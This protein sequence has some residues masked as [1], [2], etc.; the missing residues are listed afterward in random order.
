MKMI[1]VAALILAI[2]LPIVPARE[3]SPAEQTPGRPIY[4][5][6]QYKSPSCWVLGLG[7]TY[8]LGSLNDTCSLEF[9]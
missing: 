9:F 2:I 7:F 6:V 8:Y 5:P 4:L 1:I 3:L